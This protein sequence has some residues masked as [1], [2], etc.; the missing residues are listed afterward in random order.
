MRIDRYLHLCYP[1][2]YQ[3]IDQ[4]LANIFCKDLG[5]NYFRLCGLYSLCCSHSVL[6]LHGNGLGN[7]EKNRHG[8]VPV[9]LY[10]QKQVVHQLRPACCSLPIR[11]RIL[12]LLRKVPCALPQS[13]APTS[14]Q[15]RP[16]LSFF[17]LISLSCSRPSYSWNHTMCTLI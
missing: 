5:S 8:C 10:S 2:H 13:V 15:S 17:T 6:L 14:L 3:N 12:P 11:C 1:S 4:V 16:L 9:Q 7:M